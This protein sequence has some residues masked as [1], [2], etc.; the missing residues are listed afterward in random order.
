MSTAP[1]CHF[2]SSALSWRLALAMLFLLTAAPGSARCAPDPEITALPIATLAAEAARFDIY[3]SQLANGLRL[4]VLPVHRAPVV[5]QMLFFS[6]GAADEPP[7]QSGMA[8]LLEH[9]MF[10]GGQQDQRHRLRNLL[11]KS[12]GSENAWTSHDITAYYRSYPRD[13]LPEVMAL[14]AQTLFGFTINP[15]E[16]ATEMEVI[17]KE[18]LERVESS[19]AA[20]LSQLARAVLH[21]QHPYGRPV[22]GWQEEFSTLTPEQVYAFYQNWYTPALATLVVAGDVT[23][24]EVQARA[25]ETYGRVA[26]APA[27]QHSRPKTPQTQALRRVELSSPE[28][29][30]PRLTLFY[31]VPQGL[32]VQDKFALEVLATVLGDS[33]I[34]RLPRRLMRTRK[35]AVTAGAFFN[36]NM[37]DRGRF[38]LWAQAT[39]GVTKDA[40]EKELQ[41]ELQN[42]ISD[43]PTAKEITAAQRSLLTSMITARGSLTSLASAL[44]SALALGETSKAVTQAPSHIAAVTPEQI[45]ALAQRVFQPSALVTALLLPPPQDSP[46]DSAQDSPQDSLKARSNSGAQP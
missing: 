32:T 28:L 44:G 42:L 10:R 12:G 43:P 15:Q 40:L 2:V 22:L 3:E 31:L 17:E 18:R 4:V 39:A 26:L 21:L 37:R 24:K 9:L 23:P 36:G 33:Q 35:T 13:L 8:H 1:A 41:A 27:R 46:Q 25:E 19:P 34:G 5:T 20:R 38:V 11:H 29:Q 16:F 14:D 6:V 30:D 7:R 45:A